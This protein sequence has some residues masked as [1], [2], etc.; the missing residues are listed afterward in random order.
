M[1]KGFEGDGSSQRRMRHA[2]QLGYSLSGKGDLEIWKEKVRDFLKEFFAYLVD[3]LF[4]S[5]KR[6]SLD[7]KECGIRVR[8]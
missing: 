4:N 3:C 5:W 1:S 7:E 2:D 8:E 6:D